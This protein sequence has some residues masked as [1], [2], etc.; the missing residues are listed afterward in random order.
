MG[1]LYQRGTTWWIQFYQD[2]QRVRMT[3]ES[4]DEAVARRMLKEHEARV[5]LKEPVVAQAARVTYDDLRT[6]LVA[7]YQ[8]TGSRDLA[9]AGCRL[10]HLDRAFRG[11][12]ASRITGAVI[13]K[14]IVQRQQ[15]EIVSSQEE[16]PAAPG[17]RHDRARSQR[18]AQDAAAR[19]RAQ[20]S[21]P[22]ADRA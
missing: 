19:R 22:A 15:E 10:K 18:P 3:S 11:V 6:D 9:E 13:T 5:T 14:Y 17:Q 7:H 20:Q 8:A 4:A 1:H 16:I 21:E 2:G 12:R